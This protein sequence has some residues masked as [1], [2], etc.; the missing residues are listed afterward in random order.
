MTVYD[1]IRAGYLDGA[2][3]N[4]AAVVLTA[5][6]AGEGFDQTAYVKFVDDGQGEERSIMMK[7]LLPFVP[8]SIDE[9]AVIING[10]NKGELVKVR[11]RPDRN[12]SNELV[13]VETVGKNGAPFWECQKDWMCAL[14][15]A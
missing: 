4:R 10:P 12:E 9:E 2:Y 3:E 5:S 8:D 7:Y 6:R 15:R 14:S 13:V 11:Q 1:T